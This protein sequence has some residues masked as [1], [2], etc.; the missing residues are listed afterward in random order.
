MTLTNQER[1]LRCERAIQAYSNDDTCTNL[2]D[3]LADAMH[4]C[5]THGHDF[6]RLLETATYH[7]QIETI[8][9]IGV[10]P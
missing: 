9:E 10:F 1:A 4:W 6:H 8:E 3:F 2:V 5:R 7:F